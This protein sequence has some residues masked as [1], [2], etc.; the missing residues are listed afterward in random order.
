[1]EEWQETVHPQEIEGLQ[2]SNWAQVEPRLV[3]AVGSLPAKGAIMIQREY[4]GC[5]LHI[6][7]VDVNGQRTLRAE[8][9]NN[10]PEDNPRIADRG[11]VL[12]DQFA[13][14]WRRDVPWPSSDADLKRAVAE[15]THVLRNIWREV[16]LSGFSYLAWIEDS[17]P[18]AWMFWKPKK[19]KDLRFP[20]LGLPKGDG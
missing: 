13:G 9:C 4:P 7:S 14:V 15:A 11:W 10:N 17:A 12:K 18:P 19:D 20:D 2:M 1:M 16:T 8:V 5:Q 3:E 6:A